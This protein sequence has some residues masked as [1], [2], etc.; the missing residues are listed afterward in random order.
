MAAGLTIRGGK[1]MAKFK[2]RK[3]SFKA[4]TYNERRRN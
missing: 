1:L 4:C 2:H 3:Y